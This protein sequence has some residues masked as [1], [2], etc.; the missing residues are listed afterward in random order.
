MSC[1]EARELMLECLTG[2]VTPDQRRAVEGHLQT[3]AACRVQAHGVEETVALLRAVPEPHLSQAHWTEFM[4]A[5]QHRLD[6]DASPV[7]SRFRRWVAMPR[8]AW[9]T[10]AAASAL[11]VLLGV[12]LVVRSTPVPQ[13]VPLAGLPEGLR[14]L[15][16]E[17]MARAMPSMASSLDIWNDQLAAEVLPDQESTGG[18]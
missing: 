9:R 15:V 11:V 17:S 13:P 12:S 3:C 4:S 14:G 10:A 5:L 7:W 18:E 6:R 16:T 8:V 1:R 2:S